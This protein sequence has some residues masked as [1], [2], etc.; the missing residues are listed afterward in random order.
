MTEA[1]RLRAQADRC[2]RLA[3]GTV[4]SAIGK[5]MCE[6]AAEYLKRARG[7]EGDTDSPAGAPTVPQAPERH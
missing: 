5:A 3:K 4:A 7:L 1:E 6:L 2:L